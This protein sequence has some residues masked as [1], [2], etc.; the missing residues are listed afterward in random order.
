MIIKGCVLR[1]EEEHGEQNRA[2]GAIVRRTNCKIQII[3]E[4]LRGKQREEQEEE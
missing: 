3:Y 2:E 4:K 1:N